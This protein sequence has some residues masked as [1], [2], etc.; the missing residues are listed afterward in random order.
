MGNNSNGNWS[1]V[2]LFRW[3]LNGW[4]IVG[5]GIDCGSEMNGSQNL[6]HFNYKLLFTEY[7]NFN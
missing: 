4:E 2:N 7:K 6:M 1:D 3:K 5:M